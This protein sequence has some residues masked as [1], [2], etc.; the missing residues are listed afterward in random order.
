M[1]E[2]RPRLQLPK[3]PELD[4]LHLRAGEKR[5]AGSSEMYLRSLL[6]DEVYEMWDND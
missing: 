1:N 4:R 2:P 6:G 5:D 3:S